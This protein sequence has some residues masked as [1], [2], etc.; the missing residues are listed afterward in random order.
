MSRSEQ[1]KAL[2]RSFVDLL[3]MAKEAIALYRKRD[4][5]GEA[6]SFEEIGFPEVLTAA[7]VLVAFG[8]GDALRNAA[9]KAEGPA[10]GLKPSEIMEEARVT[11]EPAKAHDAFTQELERQKIDV[12]AA[13]RVC[14]ALVSTPAGHDMLRV[15]LYDA[16]MLKRKNEARGGAAPP[17]TNG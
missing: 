12:P 7:H 15:M 13:R 1:D 9:A 11:V 10:L 2:V 17:A 5:E 14:A 6:P 4:N 3:Q 16:V 8:M